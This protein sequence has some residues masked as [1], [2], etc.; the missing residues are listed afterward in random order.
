M[1]DEI[2]TVNMRPD[3]FVRVEEVAQ[4]IGVSK[5]TIYGW[6]KRGAFPKSYQLN[7]EIGSAVA[8]RESE[9]EQWMGT[10]PP[11]PG[12][13]TPQAWVARWAKHQK[14]QAR[15]AATNGA[16]PPKPPN[17]FKRGT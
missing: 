17:K 10:R 9:I 14:R 13:G 2:N 5:F 11:G 8:W 6:V 7:P 12:R 15:E 16:V 1:P 4:R 3:R